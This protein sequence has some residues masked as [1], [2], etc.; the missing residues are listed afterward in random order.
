MG[1]ANDIGQALTAFSGAVAAQSSSQEVPKRSVPVTEANT[2]NE[3]LLG[4]AYDIG[5]A[6]LSYAKGVTEVPP[7]QALAALPNE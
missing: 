4:L 2:A 7:V 6:P 3:G 1:L 5:T